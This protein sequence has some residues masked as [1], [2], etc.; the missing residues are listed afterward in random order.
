MSAA[1]GKDSMALKRWLCLL[2]IAATVFVYWPAHKNGFINYDDPDYVTSNPRTQ[3]GLTMENVRWA[4]TQSHSSNWHPLT[5]LSHM[6]DC[7]LFGVKPASHHLVNVAFHTINVVLLFLLL[8]RLTGAVYRSAVV[9][10]LFA[11]HPLHVESVAWVSER[12]DILSTFFGLLT[13]LAYA[14]FV[15]RSK[16]KDPRSKIFYAAALVFFALGLLS[17]PMLVT[18]PFVLLLLDFWPLQRLQ[19]SPFNLPILYKLVLEKVPFLLLTTATCAVTMIVQRNSGATVPW[20]VLPLSARLAQMPIAYV[21]YLAK[22]FWPENLAVFYPYEAFT[23]GSAAAIASAMLLLAISAI[24]VAQ[25]RRRPFLTMGW[26][27][28]LGTFV[29]VIGLVQVGRQA[30]AD[31]YTYIPHIGLFAALIW[32]AAELSERFKVPRVTRGAAAV[33][34]LIACGVLA[35]RQL[36]HWK[37]TETLARHTIASTRNNYTAHSQLA[38][39]LLNQGK[40]DQAIDQCQEALRIRPGYSEAHNI[41]ASA[42]LKQ[43]RTEEAVA[44]FREAARNDQYYAEPHHGL[45]RVYL[46]SGKFAEAE[47]ESREALR[48]EPLHLPATYTLAQALHNQNRLDEAA[49]AYKKM[50]SLHPRLFSS[51]YGL[52]SVYV[53]KGD[54]ASAMREFEIARDIQPTNAVVYN[55]IGVLLLARGHVMEAS[56]YFSTAAMLEPTNAIAN[57]QLAALLSSARQ[58]AQAAVYYRTALNAAPNQAEVL[59]NFAWLLATSADDRVLNGS[60]AVRHAE[61]ACELTRQQ[62]PLFIGT[63]AAA[64]AAA[65]RFDDAIADATRARDLARE[66]KL[67]PVAARNEELLQLYRAHKPFREAKP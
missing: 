3:T 9:A 58:D 14:G 62:A 24:V 11:L 59:N 28:F 61:R 66:Q 21:R 54:E 53:L 67:E 7:E 41:L 2:L 65:G 32:L 13:L 38:G 55:S 60:E 56:N 20:D 26:F 15:R 64:Y 29:P 57:S 37:D 23:L 17:K 25:T 30:I 18:W 8:C 22:T 45:A 39:V 31:R 51:H 36:A 48:I 44:S 5:W 40:V 42:Y 6:M 46:D 34:L 63:L 43:G 35:S 33:A 47:Q 50:D 27:W 16:T 4:F 19:L 10:A 1:P 52:G 49:V 12:K